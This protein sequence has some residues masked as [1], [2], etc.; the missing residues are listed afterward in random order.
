MND[1]GRADLRLDFCTDAARFLSLAERYLAA[2]PVVSTVVT[3]NAA[4]TLT[5]Q[6]DG[7]APPE[8]DWWLVV[9]DQSGV[10]G[11]AMRTATSPP[12]PPFLLPMP[13][14]A[15]VGL[16]RVL[17][18]RG[19]EVLGINGAL[20]TV[21]LCADELARLVGGRVD[22]AYH[23]RLHELRDLVQ[24][25]AVPGELRLA[26]EGDVELATEWF[27]AFLDDADEQAGRQRGA[28]GHQ[29]TG[30]DEVLRRI[31]SH[32][33]WFWVDESGDP[34]HLTGANPP[35]LGVA[36]I[37]PVYT[38]PSQ[39]GRGWAS[40]AVAGVSRQLQAAGARV[41]LYTDQANPTSN[42]IYAALGFAPV[43][44]MANL[45]LAT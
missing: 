35:A 33:L 9:T 8:S 2:N 27:E 14:D 16:A 41:C 43:T 5:R 13:D 22:V 17:H 1:F 26:T 29:A 42:K 25:A 10:V 31:R 45:L 6:R 19:E 23:T 7:T 32:H 44:D 30:P 11:A 15:A 3:S 12:C 18:E 39:R 36:R 4:Q 28:A 20:P 34:V 37:G 21:Q 38:P 40:N 24:P